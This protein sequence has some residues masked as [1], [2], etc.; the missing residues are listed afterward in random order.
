MT[1]EIWWRGIP[2]P[3]ASRG[4]RI[5]THKNGA[6]IAYNSNQYIFVPF[7]SLPSFFLSVCLPSFLFFFLLFLF[8]FFLS[9]IVV[10]KSIT[11]EWNNHFS[12]LNM[13]F[14]NEICPFCLYIGWGIYYMSFKDIIIL[15]PDFLK[16]YLFRGLNWRRFT[17]HIVFLFS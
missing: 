14:K 10:V 13:A 7:P 2:A 4:G 15:S 1:D 9:V 8:W 17:N 16:I 6:S 12:L 3:S 5:L 11:V